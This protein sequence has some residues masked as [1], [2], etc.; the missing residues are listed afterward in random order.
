MLST[1]LLTLALSQVPAG[2]VQAPNPAAPA[3]DTTLTP[4]ERRQAEL[5]RTIELRKQHRGRVAAASRLSRAQ[6]AQHA[7]QWAQ[8]Q[9]V[10]QAQAAQ[11][12]LQASQAQALQNIAA[13]EQRRTAI[14]EQQ[15]R[16]NTQ[17]S[18][19]RKSTSPAKA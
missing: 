14:A 16:L 8:Q 5:R 2:A 6:V 1:L 9:A 15:Y 10:Q 19:P 11:L 4:A 3:D 13:A 7:Q 12:Q 18:G 17:V